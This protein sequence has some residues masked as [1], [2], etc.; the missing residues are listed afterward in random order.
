MGR[1]LKLGFLA[2]SF[3]KYEDGKILS[4]KC[5]CPSFRDEKTFPSCLI[6][7]LRPIRGLESVAETIC[8]K[9]LTPKGV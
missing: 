1:N 8:Y 9:D 2:N 4:V 6:L 3:L 5:F 7:S